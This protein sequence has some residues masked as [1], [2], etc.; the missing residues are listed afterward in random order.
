[1][2][3]GVGLAGVLLGLGDPVGQPDV[4][5][6]PGGLHG[7]QGHQDQ[8]GHQPDNTHRHQLNTRSSHGMFSQHS[9]PVLLTQIH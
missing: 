3:A 9:T 7:Q 4:C 6:V 8:A 2:G 1:M 5:Q